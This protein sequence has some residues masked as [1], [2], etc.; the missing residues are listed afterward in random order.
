MPAFAHLVVYV[1]DDSSECELVRSSSSTLLGGKW[2]ITLNTTSD[3]QRFLTDCFLGFDQRMGRPCLMLLD[4][5]LGHHS[6]LEML[7]WLKTQPFSALP[8]AMFSNCDC[9]EDILA[10][11]QAGASYY[12]RKPISFKRLQ[13]VLISLQSCLA[14][15]QPN[16]DCLR[17]LEE[18]RGPASGEEGFFLKPEVAT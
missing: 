14:S 2:L 15:D 9:E 12:L 5:N 17:L 8:V 11:Y 6:G 3:A 10:C 18:Y 7:A 16:F 4:Y 13:A 1:D